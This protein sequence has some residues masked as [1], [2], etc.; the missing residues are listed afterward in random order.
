MGV[1]MMRRQHGLSLVELMVAL[2]LMVLVSSIAIPAY[3]DY[4]ATSRITVMHQA[5]QNLMPFQENYRIDNGA[6]LA[7]SYVPGVT[8]DFED[9]L[10]FRMDGDHSQISLE[11]AACD[12]GTLNDCYKVTAMNQV[13]ETVVYNDGQ[14]V[15]P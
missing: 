6:Y 11:V 3:Q 10:G 2:A 15:D 12:G 4:I 13:G 5:I 7:G 1:P 8:N 14:F 9:T